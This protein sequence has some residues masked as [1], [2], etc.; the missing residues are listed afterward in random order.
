MNKSKVMIYA[1]AKDQTG[2]CSKICPG[3]TIIKGKR[4]YPIYA[5]CGQLKIDECDI[6]KIDVDKINFTKI[7]VNKK[8]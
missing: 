1:I 4:Y 6:D 7:L 8:Q 2:I 5:D 3:S